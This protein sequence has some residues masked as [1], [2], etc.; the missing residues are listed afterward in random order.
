MTIDAR[1]HRTQICCVYISRVNFHHNLVTPLVSIWI[2]HLLLL[3][4]VS[5]Q[6]QRKSDRNLSLGVWWVRHRNVSY[7]NHST[8]AT[9]LPTCYASTE[10]HSLSA[11]NDTNIISFSV[12][13]RIFPAVEF[14]NFTIAFTLPH[15]MAPKFAN[16]LLIRNVGR[17]WNGSGNV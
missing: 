14:T 4:Y 11:S 13:E 8:S 12:P 16:Q 5:C 6:A 17:T 15:I 7:P 10:S 2:W 1:G 3:F 9:T